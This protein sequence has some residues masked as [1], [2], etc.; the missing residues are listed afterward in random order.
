MM[1]FIWQHILSSMAGWIGI[2]GAIVLICV[3]VAYFFPPFRRAAIAV[4]ITTI[5][6]VG[7]YAKGSRDRA[8]LERKKRDKVVKKVTEKYDEIDKRVDTDDDVAKRMRDGSF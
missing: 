4:A 7:L 3:A 8:A 2:G 6:A 1:D 5:A